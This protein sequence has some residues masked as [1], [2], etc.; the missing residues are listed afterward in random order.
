MSESI[1]NDCVS[2]TEWTTQTLMEKHRF[3]PYNPDIA[4]TFFRAGFIES[5][6]RGIEK[7]CSIC[8]EYGNPSVPRNEVYNEVFEQAENFKKY[9]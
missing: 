6:G 5:W 1:S 4:N 3:N 7:I 2:L 9:E 8:K